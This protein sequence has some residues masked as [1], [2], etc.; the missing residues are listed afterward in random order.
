M[1]DDQFEQLTRHWENDTNYLVITIVNGTVQWI[2]KCKTERG[3][4]MSKRQS[5]SLWGPLAVVK[6]LKLEEILQWD[7]RGLEE[8][9]ML[10]R[11]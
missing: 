3:A 2:S 11:L 8:L 5:V 6:I 7:D 9:E 4:A 1:S 10:G